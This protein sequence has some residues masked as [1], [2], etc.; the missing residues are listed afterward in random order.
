MSVPQ[1]FLQDLWIRKSVGLAGFSCL[2]YDYILIL[3]EEVKFIWKAPWSFTKVIFLVNRYGN[4][5]GQGFIQVVE[6]GWVVHDSQDL[7]QRFNLFAS[8]FMILSAE[9]IHILVLLRAWA[10]WGCE[11]RVATVLIGVYSV[12]LFLML[13]MVALG[14]NSQSFHEFQYLDLIGVCV[15]V[16]PRMW[17]LFWASL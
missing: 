4:L 7:C 10:I 9:S 13:I 1:S 5:L 14:M 3:D 15:G 8:I 6:T 12:Y 2:V 16:I 11:R 17:F